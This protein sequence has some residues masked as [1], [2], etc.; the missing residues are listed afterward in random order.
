MAIKLANN[1]KLKEKLKKELKARA[2]K[3]LFKNIKALKTHEKFLEDYNWHE[4]ALNCRK[5]VIETIFV[6][7]LYFGYLKFI[8]RNESLADKRLRRY[9]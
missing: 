3:Y 2:T 7:I 9:F 8:R 1:K 5:M 6:T 4:I